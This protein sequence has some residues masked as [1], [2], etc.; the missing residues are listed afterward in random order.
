MTRVRSVGLSF[1]EDLGPIKVYGLVAAHHCVVRV[2]GEEKGKLYALGEGEFYEYRGEGIGK[3]ELSWVGCRD[4]RKVV[5][6]LNES[7]DAELL[8]RRKVEMVQDHE[9]L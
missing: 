3:Y 9:W 1:G 6:R 5:E 8:E 2:N 7:L 4:K